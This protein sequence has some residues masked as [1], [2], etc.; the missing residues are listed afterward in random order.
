MADAAFSEQL[1]KLE[2]RRAV[3]GVI[4]LGYVGLP[5]VRLFVQAGFRTFGFDCDG[6]KVEALNAGQSYIKHID[7]SLIRE[8][9]DTGR[10]HPTTDF[11]ELRQ[12]DA[13][14]IC[15]PTPLTENHEPDMS[16]VQGTARS[17]R[18]NLT[19]GQLV[20]LESTTYPG[21]LRDVVRPILEET[22]M[23]AGVDFYMAYSPEIGRAHV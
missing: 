20:V 3:V 19:R 5:L 21:T 12:V 22:G 11:C 6:Q 14:L 4:G 15:V 2:S 16:Y 7:S 18:D 23:K 1:A 8:M 10:F 13:I 9:V 17:I